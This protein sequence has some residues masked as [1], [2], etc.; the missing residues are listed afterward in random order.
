VEG[1]GNHA[2]C[3]CEILRTY[4][5]DHVFLK[6]NRCVR[7]RPAVDNVGHGYWQD[8]GIGSA[9]V[10]VQWQTAKTGSSLGTGQGYSQDGIGAQLALVFCPSSAIIVLSMAAWSV[11]SISLTA[12][13]S[14]HS[15][16]DSLKHTLAQIA[17]AVT[18][19]QFNCFCF[20]SGSPGGHG[21]PAE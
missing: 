2:Q 4:W 16:F 13:R 3:F 9:Q 19:A 21:C 12:V 1:L 5:H 20:S 17:L 6:I 11:T 7:M 18:V 14:P 15:I 10:M 8:A